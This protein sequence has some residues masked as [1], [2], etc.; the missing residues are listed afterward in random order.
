MKKKKP[1]KTVNAHLEQEQIERLD[2][3]H[4]KTRVP[5]QVYIR[6]GIEMVLKKYEGKNDGNRR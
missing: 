1:K 4:E 6:E 2:K 5:R 3:L